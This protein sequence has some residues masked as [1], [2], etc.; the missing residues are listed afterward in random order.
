MPE[1]MDT[2]KAVIIWAQNVDASIKI[3][4]KDAAVA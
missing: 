4:S 3:E 1:N 2:D